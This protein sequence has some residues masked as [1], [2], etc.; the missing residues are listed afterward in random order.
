MY[1]LLAYVSSESEEPR[2][3]TPDL[4][5]VNEPLNQNLKVRCRESDLNLLMI[6]VAPFFLLPQRNCLTSEFGIRPIGV[7]ASNNWNVYKSVAQQT[8]K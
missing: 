5:D 8:S 1:D 2:T 4:G 6:S 3:S 7:R